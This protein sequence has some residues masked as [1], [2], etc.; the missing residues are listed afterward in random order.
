M[1]LTGSQRLVSMIRHTEVCAVGKACSV[2]WALPTGN[3]FHIKGIGE[4]FMEEVEFEI[5][6]V[7]TFSTSGAIDEKEGRKEYKFF[8]P[9]RSPIGPT[10]TLCER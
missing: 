8:R 3:N 5:F 7:T 1:T 6:Q 9:K 4:L 10:C 2:L